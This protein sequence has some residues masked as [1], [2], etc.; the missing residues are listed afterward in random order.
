MILNKMHPELFTIGSFTLHSYGVMIALAF[1]AG[2]TASILIGKRESISA[3]TVLDGVLWVM[4]A[5]IV[6]ARLFYVV[7]FW[8]T[9]SSPLDMLR[10]WEGGLVFYGGMFF[11]VLAL[12]LFG[13]TKKIPFLKILDLAAPATA[14][15][16]AI[17][18]IGCFLNGCCRGIDGHPVQLYSTMIWSVLFVFLVVLHGRKKFDGQVFSVGLILYSGYRFLMEFLRVNPRYLFNLSE[19]QLISIL[20]FLLGIILYAKTKTR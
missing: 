4:L 10:V 17:G 6:G 14:I 9:F 13:F 5:S 8:N 12:I 2:I 7:E 11:G 1:L 20:F 18:R 16:Y 15:G 3:E 19:A